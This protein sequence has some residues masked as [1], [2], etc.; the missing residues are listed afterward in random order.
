MER[1][2]PPPFVGRAAE[3]A[4][5]DTVLDACGD[6]GP[7]VVDV[8]GE[9]GIGKS[10]LLGRFTRRAQQRGYVVLR[11]RATE[12]ER[13]SP[14]QPF[15]DAL[16]DLGEQDARGLPALAALTARHSVRDVAQALARTPSPGLVISLDDLHWADEA[17]VRLLD[18]LVRHPVAAP[19]LIVVARRVR[20]SPPPLSAALARGTDMGSVARLDVRAL[21]P[22]EFPP[23]TE[24]AY[25]DSAGNPLYMRALTAA[26]AGGGTALSVLSVVLDELAPLALLE[27]QVVEAVCVLGAQATTGLTAAVVQ[28]DGPALL[29]ALRAVMARDLVRPGADGHGLAARHPVFARLVL[30]GLDPWHRRDLHRRAAAA[31]AETGAPASVRADH[32]ERTLERWEPEAGAVLV[33][34][35][36]QTAVTDP[37]A[38]ARRLATALRLL[39]EDPSLH[40]DTRGELM[41]LRA[42]ALGAAGAVKES[43]DLLHELIALRPPDPGGDELR[44]AAVLL[45]ALMERQ[46]YRYPEADALLR[47]ELD[48]RPGPP[49]AQRDALVVE[50]GN[51][52]LFATRFP[53]VREEL[54]RTLAAT[55]ARGDRLGEAETLTLAALGEAYEG[56]TDAARQYADAGAALADVLPDADLVGLGEPMV[57]L[58]WSEVFLDRY[59]DALR[60]TDRGIEVARRSGRPFTVSQLH[61]CAAYALCQQGRVAE[62]LR[63]AD[64][65]VTVAR[66]LGGG[67]RLGFS[68]AMRA[69]VLLQARPPGDPEVLAEAEEA[70]AAVGPV[71][72][73]WATLARC[74]VAYA[75]QSAGD[76]LRVRDV[77][78]SAGGGRDLPRVQP[79]VRPSFLELLVGSALETGDVA[80]AEHW[81]RLAA[82]EA[83]RL[84][85]PTQTGA[86]LRA[87]AMVEGRRGRPDAA[88]RAFTEAAEA[89]FRSG[90]G[91]REAHS[92]LLAVPYAKAA[93]D[94]VG[95]S[96]LWRRGHRIAADGGAVLLLALADRLRPAESDVTDVPDV[97]AE[98]SRREREV[99]ELVAAGLTNQA[100]AEKLHLSTRTVESHVAR[101][102]RKTGVGSRAA[103]A[104][105]VTRI[106]APAGG[107]R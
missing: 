87:L 93:G 58:A 62:A 51:H 60:H 101:V 63:L 22:Q 52:S 40:R 54:T 5:L 89:S 78:L 9:P 104:A 45:C 7:A 100:V 20:Q 10:R 68:V 37:A 107:P 69:T 32:I 88:A 47:R 17:S 81:T 57:R 95:A 72:G 94:H 46:L 84:D 65:S 33:E 42:R 80:D 3:L 14:L 85:L 38:T 56:E 6:D 67:E 11:G 4:T 21:E 26:G 102:Y 35:A 83:R 79:S 70:V 31:L 86:A 106:S 27:R 55:R 73:W 92:A 41:L 1:A 77:L 71:D 82:A 25:A 91:L 64:E 13:S 61:L 90:A 43:R 103:L 75:V 74:L 76:P 29:T 59:A 24:A 19:V 98:L 34:A 15:T 96:A 66:G 28:T 36:V 50:W 39:P 44:T 97:L 53:L 8:T 12:A 105:L 23:G 16:T 99:A 48:R 18:H 49:P 30:D 2:H